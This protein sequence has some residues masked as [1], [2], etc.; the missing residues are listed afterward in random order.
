MGT[1]KFTKQQRISTRAVYQEILKNG[2]KVS[3]GL[4]RITL[5]FNP[6][7]S[8]PKLGIIVSKKIGPAVSRSRIKRVIREIFRL[9]QNLIVAE[10][11]L[12]VIAKPDCITQE[13]REIEKSLLKLLDRVN[14]IKKNVVANR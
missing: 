14:G 3:D 12:V 13:Y 4:F 8:R 5:S 7:Q 9:N 1:L 11:N 2:K 10:I 6:N